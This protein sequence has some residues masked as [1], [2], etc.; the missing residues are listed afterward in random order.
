MLI[1]VNIVFSIILILFVPVLVGKGIMGLF[2]VEMILSGEY[3]FGWIG[4]WS[5]CQ[6]IS[7][8]LILLRQSVWLVIVMLG[9]SILLLSIYG[10]KKA[11]RMEWRLKIVEK[12]MRYRILVGV[13]ILI[14]LFLITVFQH[15]DEDDSRFVVNVVDI[16][17]T[18]RMFLSDP[19]TG[20]PSNT[21][22]REVVKDVTSPWAVFVAFCS[23]LTLIHPTIM[24][25]TVLP[26]A[27][28]LCV[29]A[30]YWLLAD[31]FFKSDIIHKTI[32]IG[33]LFLLNIY[34][35]FSVYSS[36]TFMM[37][38]IWQGKAVVAAVGVPVIF[39]LFLKAYNDNEL[40]Y[41]ILLIFSDLAM[42]LMSGMGILIAAIMIGSISFIYA[43]LKKNMKILWYYWPI[44]I[45]N[46]IYY[47][48]YC[49][50]KI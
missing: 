7:V 13:M 10:I 38:R 18:N 28:F 35:C 49:L 3:I 40:K 50:L 25:H 2:H 43:I 48:I 39:Y 47:A 36:E 12:D 27:L 44:V 6:L 8:P 22:V 11:D 21:W 23:K 15:T 19:A 33:I 41:R 29:A 45:L 20:M 30:I 9:T 24:M 4:I 17:R 37:T 42:C 31:F 5:L 14:M 1:I 16:C 34:G 32:F 46:G 26:I